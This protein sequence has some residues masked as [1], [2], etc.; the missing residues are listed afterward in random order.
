MPAAVSPL[1]D[2]GD[3]WFAAEAIAETRACTTVGG[4]QAGTRLNLERPLRL[5]GTLDGHVVTGHVD[6]V[7][8]VLAVVPEGGSHRLRI[9]IAPPLHRLIAKKGSVALDGVSLTVVDTEGCVFDVCI[10]PHSW[11]VTTL[12]ALAPGSRVNVET[13][14]WRAIAPAGPKPRMRRAGL[15]SNGP[16]RRRI[17]LCGSSR[18]G[19]VDRR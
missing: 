12:S 7:G 2:K 14:S 6:G 10:I 1:V 9:R 3:G 16:A 19:A 15:R 11:D 8:E 4:W 5:G 17:G 18:P 13:T